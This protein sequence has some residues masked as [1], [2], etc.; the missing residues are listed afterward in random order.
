MT[1][2]QYEI[3]YERWL[4]EKETMQHFLMDHG[5]TEVP[6]IRGFVQKASGATDFETEIV[7]VFDAVMWAA[8]NYDIV[9]KQLSDAYDKIEELKRT[10]SNLNTILA[11]SGITQQNQ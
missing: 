5:R 2:K 11:A 10:N 7:P 8:R 9:R 1:D 3:V 4:A 6:T